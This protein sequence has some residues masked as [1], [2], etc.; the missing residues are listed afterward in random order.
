M[1]AQQHAIVIGQLLDRLLERFAK[2]SGVLPLPWRE[3]SV[4]GDL[5]QAFEHGVIDR[6]LAPAA[7]VHHRLTH[8]DR[9]HPAAQ[10]ALAAVARDAWH[11]VA[12]D[13]QE[14]ADALANVVDVMRG[15]PGRAKRRLER[16]DVVALERED[17]GGLADR[18]GTGEE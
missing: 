4:A 18:A 5:G 14:L 11:I 8:R 13:E 17:R 12:A 15:E 9:A 7:E 16:G 6:R 1:L 10:L 2:C 3:L